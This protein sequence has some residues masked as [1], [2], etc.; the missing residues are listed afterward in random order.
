MQFALAFAA[1]LFTVA[2]AVFNWD[3]FF[4]NAKARPFVNW[5]GREGARVFYVLL[6][7]AIMALSFCFRP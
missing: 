1:G 7:C 2:G 4:E 6:G 3:W 5:F